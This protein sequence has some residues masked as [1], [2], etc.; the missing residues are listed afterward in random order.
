MRPMKTLL[1]A[2]TLFLAACG[3][4]GDFDEVDKTKPIAEPPCKSVPVEQR[5][6]TCGT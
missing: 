5:E 2:V 1:L 3:G 4:G 6:A